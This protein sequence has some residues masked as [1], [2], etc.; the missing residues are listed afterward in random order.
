MALKPDRLW[1]RWGIALGIFGHDAAIKETYTNIPHSE[2]K[3]DTFVDIG[4][5]YGT[6]SL[7]L[8]KA[9]VRA[10]AFEPN[11][12]CADFADELFRLNNVTVDWHPLALG[13]E[14]RQ[15]I[16]TYPSGDFSLGSVNSSADSP[17]GNNMVR[18]PVEQRRLDDYPIGGRKVL[19]KIDVEG[20]ERDVL[21]GG[22]AFIAVVRPMIIFES[23][24][25]S[26]SRAQMYDFFATS[27]Y[28]LFD[29]PWHPS[30]AA[31]PLQSTSFF[32]SKATNFLA[33]AREARA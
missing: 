33:M 7:L 5:N 3:P 24:V 9:G 13:R 28:A 11:P 17:L 29:L 18:I 14:Q 32:A 4:A 16:L 19:I 27:G 21:S 2:H 25:D 31:S 15:M 20:H 6:H 26:R 30:S 10:I 8:A 12:E 22:A 1:E 23:N